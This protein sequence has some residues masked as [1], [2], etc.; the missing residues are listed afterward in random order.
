MYQFRAL[1]RPKSI[2]ISSDNKLVKF[3]APPELELLEEELELLLEELLLDDEELL[4]ELLLDEL[5]LEELLDELLLLEELLLEL[6]LLDELEVSAGGVPLYPSWPSRVIASTRYPL[7]TT[8]L[9]TAKSARF[10]ANVQSALPQRPVSKLLKSS[11][12]ASSKFD[13]FQR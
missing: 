8:T 4:E 2:N 1:R 11:R 6:L 10:S 3:S 13:P 7:R 9:L 5:L 12:Q